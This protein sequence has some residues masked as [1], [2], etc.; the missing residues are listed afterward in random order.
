MSLRGHNLKPCK[1]FMKTTSSRGHHNKYD[2]LVS[3]LEINRE[4]QV[5]VGDITYYMVDSSLY[6]I[7]HFV[8]FYTLVVNRLIAN[9]NMEGNNAEKNLRQIFTCNNRK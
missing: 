2:N 6:F 8:D 3:G 1:S 5:I 9:V 7:F 4:N